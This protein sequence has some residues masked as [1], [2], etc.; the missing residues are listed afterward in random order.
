[1]FAR[2]EDKLEETERVLTEKVKK[3]FR[4]TAPY[5]L[6]GVT[7]SVRATGVLMQQ[8]RPTM[9]E[10]DRIWEPDTLHLFLAMCLPIKRR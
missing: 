10:V 1:M 3:L 9:A 4:N 8:V 2:F 6:T 5:F 7:I